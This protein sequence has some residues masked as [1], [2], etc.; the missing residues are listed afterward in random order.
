LHAG[1]ARDIPFRWFQLLIDCYEPEA[2]DR[3]VEELRAHADDSTFREDLLA[4]IELLPDLPTPTR[5]TRLCS[6]SM[7]LKLHVQLPKC[8]KNF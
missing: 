6:S 3:I 2:V 1:R 4:L 5:K 7:I 8:L